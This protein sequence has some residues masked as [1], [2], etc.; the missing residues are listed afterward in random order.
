MEL[1]QAIQFDMEL[2]QVIPSLIHSLVYGN[3]QMID[4]FIDN[5][6]GDN[7]NFVYMLIKFELDFNFNTVIDSYT[8]K[9]FGG[10]YPE[11]AK[12]HQ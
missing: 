11:G 3:C 6:S 5:I 4:Q 2:D 1:D 10:V 7:C 12:S 8:T 9:L